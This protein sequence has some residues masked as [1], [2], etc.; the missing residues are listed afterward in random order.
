MKGLVC[1]MGGCEHEVWMGTVSDA[2][3]I[4]CVFD[5]CR[6]SSYNADIANILL[7]PLRHDPVELGAI[8]SQRVKNNFP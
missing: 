8:A 4:D 5:S 7:H 1:A 3:L 6:V 2:Q